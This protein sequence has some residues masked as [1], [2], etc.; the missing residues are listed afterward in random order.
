M[1]NTSEPANFGHL[2]GGYDA[3]YYGYA[4]SL[5]YAKDLFG[6]FKE[7]G[8]LNSELGMKLRKQVLS[9]G[10]MR[11]SMESIKEFLGREPSNEEFIKSIC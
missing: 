7:H 6:Q 2:L 9:Q 1:E 8:L 4:W 11:K 5:V 10:S 3:G